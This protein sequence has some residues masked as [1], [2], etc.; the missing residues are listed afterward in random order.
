[1]LF[2]YFILL[3]CF[4]VYSRARTGTEDSTNSSSHHRYSP[5]PSH[6][7]PADSSNSNGS[8]SG[9]G[10]GGGRGGRG[11][12]NMST[13]TATI[14]RFD[15]LVTA[16]DSTG[17]RQR[18]EREDKERK[19]EHIR[20]V[21]RRDKREEAM[22]NGVG[23]EGGEPDTARGG[24]NKGG[25][26][27]AGQLKTANLIA[28]ATLA[29]ERGRTRYGPYKARDVHVFI[30]FIEKLDSQVTRVG[31]EKND[32][33]DAKSYLLSDVLSQQEVLHK[34]KFNRE[35]SRIASKNNSVITLLDLLA[36][37]F[38][39]ASQAEW[40]RMKTLSI[41]KKL[42]N[43]CLSSLIEPA[44]VTFTADA[45][46]PKTPNKTG[47]GLGTGIGM[48]MGAGTGAGADSGPIPVTPIASA[49]GGGGGSSSSLAKK[50]ATKATGASASASAS[51]DAGAGS[52]GIDTSTPRPGIPQG[53][54]TQQGSPL[55]RN[56]SANPNA[57]APPP[58]AGR[59]AGKIPTRPTMAL[60]KLPFEA[61]DDIRRALDMLFEVE[62]G[63]I[64]GNDIIDVFHMHDKVKALEP[65]KTMG[66]Y[67][68][69]HG[70]NLQEEMNG[71]KF[72]ELLEHVLQIEILKSVY[73]RSHHRGNDAS[74]NATYTRVRLLSTMIHNSDLKKTAGTSA[75][76]AQTKTKVG[77]PG[78]AASPLFPR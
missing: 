46:P 19:L 33:S 6:R 8:G 16:E 47:V 76:H 13:L 58:T 25:V 75:M 77:G 70:F 15:R 78:R 26:V 64:T 61:A 34:P 71:Q 9:S 57:A 36:V 1:M 12:L 24:R 4:I 17:D 27:P 41:A 28:T 43:E 3:F 11:V 29:S 48:G 31:H 49:R 37:F 62:T 21:R 32:M 53:P 73:N 63:T 51:A 54:S 35:I 5:P 72:I 30:E 10:S 14:A 20:A 38:P 7:G 44:E 40:H 65:V 74:G 55:T 45:Q 67:M 66:R 42:L 52:F 59:T 23:T 50:S 22:A 60:W 2:H 68:G 56:N 18:A 69:N 39:F